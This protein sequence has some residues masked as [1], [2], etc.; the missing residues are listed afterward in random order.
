M[1]Y[2]SQHAALGR[3]ADQEIAD[4]TEQVAVLQARIDELEKPPPPPPPPAGDNH[5]GMMVFTNTATFQRDLDE[6]VATGAK[7][8]RM[9]IPAGQAGYLSGTTV[10]PHTA[11]LQFYVD[12]CQKAK[13]AGLKI[14]LV[15]GD[16]SFQ[17]TAWSDQQ[18]REIN[19]SYC[20]LVSQHIGQ[21]VDLWQIW[22]EH[23]G[24]DFR[25][26]AAI[27]PNA[28]YLTRFRDCLAY[29]RDRL[30]EHS[31]AP[32]T[33]TPFGYPVNQAR[34]DRWVL[35]F[36]GIGSALDVIGVHAYPEKAASTIG[37]VPQYMNQLKTRYGKPV[38]LLEFGLP[39]VSG[40]GT[41]T[42]VGLAIVD[43]VNAAMSAQPLCATL[44][45][46]RDRGQASSTNGE[47][48]FGV[49]RNDWTRK[50]YYPAV[51]NTVKALPTY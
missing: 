25:T 4:L 6:L 14:A 3:Q 17:N 27:T 11:N 42:Q 18:F 16:K 2:E 15:M 22:N 40:Y 44:Y 19:G 1:S 47:D 23:D 33:T 8:I 34:Y 29:C 50:S 24:R 20:K 30:R 32:V 26:F 49:V 35:F 10:M 13:A 43:Q 48:V 51:V 39:M 31:T 12:A 46:L 41:E 5:F 37:L 36:D 21:Y 38:A 45:Q 9:D 7:W 28:T